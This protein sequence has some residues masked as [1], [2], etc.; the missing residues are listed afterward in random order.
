MIG[1][2]LDQATFPDIIWILFSAL[3]YEHSNLYFE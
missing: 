3:S 2:F 1:D